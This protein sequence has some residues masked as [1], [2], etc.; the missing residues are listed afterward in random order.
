MTR[1]PEV[2]ITKA[3]FEDV[4][5]IL[6]LDLESGLSTWDANDYEAFLRDSESDLLVA[7]DDSGVPLGFL[8]MRRVGVDAE[9]LKIAVASEKRGSR[10]GRAL[11]TEGLLAARLAGCTNCFL[12]VRPSNASAIGFYRKNG[13]VDCGLRPGYYHNPPEAALLMSKDL[14]AT[15]DQG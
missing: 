7:C 3:G 9:L 12:E 2:R 10:I 4:G 6:Q 8:V 11:L 14:T 1:A 13:F 5:S 15:E